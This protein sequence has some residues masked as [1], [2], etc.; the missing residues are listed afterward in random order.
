MFPTFPSKAGQEKR[1]R[2]L[3]SPGAPAR[4]AG[5]PRMGEG[6]ENLVLDLRR[7]LF[8]VGGDEEGEEEEEAKGAGFE[9]KLI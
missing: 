1:R 5:A 4:G 7:G 6:G 9:L 2:R 8:G 3:V